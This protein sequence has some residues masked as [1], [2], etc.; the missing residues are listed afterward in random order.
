VEKYENLFLKKTSVPKTG[1]FWGVPKQ[2]INM[3]AW[4]RCCSS[5]RP[6]KIMQPVRDSH[7]CRMRRRKE[8]SMK[9]MQAFT[10]P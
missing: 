4:I 9:K 3:Y 2:G 8:M 5:Y 1:K 6:Y 7:Q 10:H